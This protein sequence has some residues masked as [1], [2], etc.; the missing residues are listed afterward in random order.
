MQIHTQ[1]EL[2]MALTPL[3]AQCRISAHKDEEI[4]GVADGLLEDSV[5]VAG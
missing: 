4:S 5:E 3:F 2:R 1:E